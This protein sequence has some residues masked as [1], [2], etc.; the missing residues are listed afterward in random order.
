MTCN[1]LIYL[2]LPIL[3]IGFTIEVQAEI[4]K[5]KDKNG[6]W[7]FTDKPPRDKKS[8]NASKST[9]T[10]NTTKV[11]SSTTNLK[12]V[13]VERFKPTTKVEEA[14]LAVV[15]VETKVGS[16]SGFFITNNGYLVTNRHVVRPS[17][18]SGWKQTEENL[19]ERKEHLEGLKL[20]VEDDE[21]TIKSQK[22][23]IDENT[24]YIES[25]NA[26][27][28]HKRQFERHIKRY[29]RNKKI[30]YEKDKRYRK[31]ERE[32]KKEKSDFD[33]ASSVSSFSKKFT[34]RLKNGDKHSA[35]LV[36]VSKKY[37]LA[38]LKLD[39]YTTPY[40]TLAKK[41][42]P[43]QG[44]K[45]YAI[46]SPLGITD[47]L[48]TG[49]VTKS[50]KD[51]LYTDTM[52]LPGNSGG[53]LVNK[54]GEVLGVNTAVLSHDNFAD[55]FGVAIYSEFIRSEFGRHLPGDI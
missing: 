20:D 40:L 55:G 2:L 49:I 46:G 32:Y 3:M 43:K 48:S 23:Y 16:G 26:T 36:K 37:D 53:P 8:T 17:T 35:K 19:L 33:W 51:N 27:A 44:V 18:S 30:L 13:L 50:N 54:K 12:T 29:N 22:E 28:S 11:K 21:L 6:K 42:Y 5:F 7:Q 4:Y 45:V 15:T 34:I 9:A 31:A 39:K 25:S 47:S 38:L 14:S 1:R 24:A 52:I 10:V 41:H